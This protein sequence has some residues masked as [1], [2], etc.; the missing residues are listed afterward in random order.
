MYHIVTHVKAYQMH[1][2]LLMAS[3]QSAGPTR[4]ARGAR[5]RHGEVQDLLDRYSQALASGHGSA[6]AATWELPAYMIGPDLIVAVDRPEKITQFLGEAKEAYNAYGIESTRPQVLD[7]EWI[8]DRLVI[9]RVRWPYLD[10]T[11]R[12]VGAERSDYTLRRDNGGALRIR[13]VL[14]RGVEGTGRAPS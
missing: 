6:A 1:T 11:G 8:G 2:R 12:E 10:E 7:E 13:S 5:E 4:G 9:V 14:M 3:Q